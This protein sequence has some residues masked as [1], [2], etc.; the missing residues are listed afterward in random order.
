[1]L[2]NLLKDWLRR[3]YLNGQCLKVCVSG[4]WYGDMP[5]CFRPARDGKGGGGVVDRGFYIS[6]ALE[7]CTFY[8]QYNDNAAAF[9]SPQANDVSVGSSS[10]DAGG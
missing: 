7:R 6:G 2:G 10:A 5:F 1:M 3:A 4:R 8:A 9:F